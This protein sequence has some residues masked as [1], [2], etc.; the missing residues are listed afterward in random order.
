MA[1][2]SER[3][4]DISIYFAQQV[5]YFMNVKLIREAY[6]GI[7]VESGGGFKSRGFGM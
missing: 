2:S 5:N 3:L 4:T 6:L 7:C 1:A